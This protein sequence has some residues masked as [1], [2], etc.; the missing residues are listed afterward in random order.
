MLDI[1]YRA[2]WSMGKGEFS[3]CFFPVSI[4]TNLVYARKSLSLPWAKSFGVDLIM[5]VTSWL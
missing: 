4:T 3:F 2:V 5:T 1:D